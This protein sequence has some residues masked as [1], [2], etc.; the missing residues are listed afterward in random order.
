M[1]RLLLVRHGEAEGNADGRFIGQ[2]DVPLTPLGR[3]QAEML[4]HHLADTP[5]DAVV[6]SDL[7]RCVDTVTPTARAAGLSV[8]TDRRLRE[9]ANGEWSGMLPDEIAQRWPGLFGRYRDGEDIARPGG[10][11]WAMVAERVVN[12]VNEIA[13]AAA[14]D[15]TILIG[16]HAGPITA[17]ARWAS[18]VPATRSVFS[19]GLGPISNTGI[20]ILRFPGP[21]LEEFNDD[22]HVA[23]PGAPHR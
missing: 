17:V 12:A 16:T 18:G 19:S 21:H 8:T 10:E 20:T 22:A 3:R 1:P 14:D 2:N 6:S 9:I 11:T 7:Q 5:L 15:A 4:R 23:D 13:N